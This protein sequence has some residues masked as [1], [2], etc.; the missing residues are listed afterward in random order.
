M[1]IAFYPDVV[2]RVPDET[3]ETG[4]TGPTGSM[5]QTDQAGSLS[6]QIEMEV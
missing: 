4:Q 3:D 2:M 1:W 6:S 5:G